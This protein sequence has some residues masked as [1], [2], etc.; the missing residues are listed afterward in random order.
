[1]A[2]GGHYCRQAILAKSIGTFIPV[3]SMANLK[4]KL[5]GTFRTVLWCVQAYF[6]KMAVIGHFACLVLPL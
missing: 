4:I 6:R 5:M 3:R 2:H 1:M